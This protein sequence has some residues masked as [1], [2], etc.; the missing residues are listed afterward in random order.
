MAQKYIT[1]EA[2]AN[3][4]GVHPRTIVRAVYNKHNVY[5]SED[6]NEDRYEIDTIAEAYGLHPR[7]LRQIIEKRDALL[8]P[9]EAAEVL[10]IKPRTFRDRVKAGAYRKIAHGSIVRYLRSEIYEARTAASV[11]E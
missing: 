4:F 10:S 3:V 1:L 5:W 8:K 2:A 9:D 6:S 7:E 11:Q